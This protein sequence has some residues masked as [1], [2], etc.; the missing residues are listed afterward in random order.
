LTWADVDWERGRLTVRSPKTEHHVGKEQRIVPISHLLMTQL[1]D[2]FEEADEGQEQIITMPRNNLHR[3]LRLIVGRAGI[4]VWSDL[5]QT[6]RRSAEIE[7]AQT[8]PQYAVSMWIGHSITVSG[9]H[10]ANNVP[11]TLFDQA[12]KAVGNPVQQRSEVGR[13]T[14]KSPNDCAEGDVHKSLVLQ[15]FSRND[16]CRHLD[17]NQGPRAYESLALTN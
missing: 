14:S 6:L 12:S 8:L 1:Q 4:N 15:G 13:N 10:Y 16:E 5:Y 7:W 17:S 11:D 3:G 2:A 9:K